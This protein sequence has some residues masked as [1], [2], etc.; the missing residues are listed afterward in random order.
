LDA[1][2]Y[3]RI[4]FLASLYLAMLRAGEA[5][6]GEMGDS[7]FAGECRAIAERGATTIEELYNG[8]YFFHE[9]DPQHVDN[10]AVGSGCYVDQVFGQFW[11]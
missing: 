4:S 9:L 1:A 8:E 7:A 11:A 5:M 2:W 3:G 10:V 6:A